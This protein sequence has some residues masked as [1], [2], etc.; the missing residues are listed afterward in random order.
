MLNPLMR[1]GRH[2]DERCSTTGG[3]AARRAPR[4]GGAA[5]GR[6][7][8]PRPDVSPTAI[9]SSCPAACASASGIAA[10]LARDPRLL[11]ADEPSTALDVT[12]QKE[13]LALLRSL[14]ERARHGPDPDHAR[15]ARRV[16]DVR[17]DLRALR[18]ARC[19]RSAPAQA[20]ERRA[21]AP[22]HARAAAVRA[23]G[24]PAPR[25][26]R[27]D[28]RLGA[29]AR[30][31]R[32]GC[33]FA[34]RCAWAQP[35]CR[36]GAPAARAVDGEARS[37]LRAHRRDPR[38]D[39]RGARGASARSRVAPQPRR[40]RRSWRV[41]DARQGLQRRRRRR[42]TRALAR[43]LARGRRRR[44]RRPRRRVGLGQDDARALPGRPRDADVRARSRSTASTPPT[45]AR[46][47]RASARRCA[48]RCR[49]SSRTRTRRSTR[50]ARSARP[51][52]EA[53]VARPEGAPRRGDV[54]GAAA[55]ASACRPTTPSA[56]RPRS[57][58][59]SASASRSPA[60]SRCSPRL[61]VCDE[62][63]SALDVSVQA[64]M[65]NLLTELRDELGRQ[66]P[67]HHPRPRGRA[68]GRRARL[69]AVQRAG[70]WRQGACGAVLDDPQHEY[71]RKLVASIPGNDRRPA[72]MPRSDEAR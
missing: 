70:S 34:P 51:C 71:T 33:A 24:G 21:A 49:S 10:A 56:S 38:R 68:P 52:S 29:A 72:T 46:S 17:P 60:R 43:R 40:P 8:H 62:P 11:I 19:S 63:V 36:D 55:S 41:R 32:H 30:R 66:L 25:A 12:T 4:G 61:I 5:A 48:A 57:R 27:R 26:A 64:Q 16:R 35:R 50:C 45:T 2:I 18:R 28:P 14:Q 20:L 15:P 31:G 6:G 39:A 7:R 23:A 22:V 37:A 67:L 42:A 9:R 69:R 53:L 1:C 44:E 59:A 65:L 3:A 13:I 47:T 58:A 54:G